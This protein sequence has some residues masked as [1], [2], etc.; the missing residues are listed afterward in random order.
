MNNTL[1]PLHD[2][3]LICTEIGKNYKLFTVCECCTIEYFHNMLGYNQY[4][5]N[6]EWMS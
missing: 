1:C 4:W 2:S 5:Q 3:L 6:R